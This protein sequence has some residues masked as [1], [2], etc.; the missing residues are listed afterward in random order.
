M[1]EPPSFTSV[2][3]RNSEEQ[4]PQVT[5][6]RMFEED[7]YNPSMSKIRPMDDQPQ[8]DPSFEGGTGTRAIVQPTEIYDDDHVE[9]VSIGSMA[10]RGGGIQL[11]DQLMDTSYNNKPALSI[12]DMVGDRGDSQPAGGRFGYDAQAPPSLSDVARRDNSHTGE[13]GG[14]QSLPEGDY[15][16]V[17]ITGRDFGRVMM[18]QMEGG[19]NTSPF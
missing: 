3:A 6:P 14:G 16:G 9:A 5:E 15:E 1:D 4:Q 8:S 7:E 11:P 12:G 10:V 13:S 18:S 19:Q 2:T 17:S